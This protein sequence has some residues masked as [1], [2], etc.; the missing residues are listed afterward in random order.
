[1]KGVPP[2]EG[3]HATNQPRLVFQKNFQDVLVA[4]S[5]SQKNGREVLLVQAASIGFAMQHKG[6]NQVLVTVLT[7]PMKR[8]I[9]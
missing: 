5:D 7:G 6:L 2:G 3:I 4:F 8:H 1:M 9:A